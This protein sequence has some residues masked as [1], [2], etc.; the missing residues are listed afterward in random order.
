MSLASLYVNTSC[1][2]I[3]IETHRSWVIHTILETGTGLGGPTFARGGDR[4]LRFLGTLGTER[5]KRRASSI[6]TTK[7]RMDILGFF[8][9]MNLPTILQ[10]EIGTFGES[11]FVF[12][13]HVP[14][15]SCPYVRMTR[16]MLAC[17]ACLLCQ[18]VCLFIHVRF[19]EA[20]WHNLHVLGK[21]YQQSVHRSPSS[22]LI[23]TAGT[24]PLIT[25]AFFRSAC[26]PQRDLPGYC[27]PGY[28]ISDCLTL[29][30]R[31]YPGSLYCAARSLNP[32]ISNLSNNNI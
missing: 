20:G 27:I 14:K 7:W 23:N 21:K 19:S 18:L 5:L 3:E 24:I 16:V 26:P 17:C 15:L 22:P 1:P 29:T 12:H 31:C 9:W 32:C 30:H 11:S 28:C 2:R 8:S 13:E 25:S 6:N 4:I 10:G